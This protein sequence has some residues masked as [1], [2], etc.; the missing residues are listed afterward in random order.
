[1]NI[2]ND[3]A[4][5]SYN[6]RSNV[7]ESRQTC[8]W[9]VPPQDHILFAKEILLALHRVRAHDVSVVLGDKA[10]PQ[11]EAP[12]APGDR[13][14]E[15]R[16]EDGADG[17]DVCEAEVVADG[18]VGAE[19]DVAAAF[20]DGASEGEEE[21]QESEDYRREEHGCFYGVEN[22]ALEVCGSTGSLIVALPWV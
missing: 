20:F 16:V 5:K 2:R 4:I 21:R 17:D 15:V 8:H 14:R 7:L 6:I 10:W 12:H 11:G 9:R 19:A 18:P 3:T 1:M 13:G 22:F